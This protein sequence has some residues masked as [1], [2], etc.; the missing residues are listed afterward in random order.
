[1]KICQ[2]HWD[3]ATTLHLCWSLSTKAMTRTQ[4][5]EVIT[6]VMTMLCV[7]LSA[8]IT[9]SESTQPKKVKIGNQENQTPLAAL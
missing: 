4:Y 9:K 3:R 7:L 1:M 5:W 2:H 6:K 8:W